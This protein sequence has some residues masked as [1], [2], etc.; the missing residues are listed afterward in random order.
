MTGK[1]I[2][3]IFVWSFVVYFVQQT[4]A[5]QVCMLLAGR[6]QFFDAETTFSFTIGR[7]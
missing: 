2:L 5:L 1:K 7:T 6:N 3:D 4:D